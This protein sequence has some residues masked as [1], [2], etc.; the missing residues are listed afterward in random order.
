MKSKIKAINNVAISFTLALS[1]FAFSSQIQADQEDVELINESFNEI[2]NGEIPDNWIL[3][4][5]NGKV[6][7]G[8]LVLSSSSASRPSRIVVPIDSEYGNYTFEADMTFE[9]SVADSRWASLMY[10]IQDENN[11]YQFAARKGASA[12]NGLEFAKRIENRWDVFQTNSYHENFHYN[13]SYHLKIVVSRDRVQQFVDN[14]LVI[15][16]AGATEWLDGDIGFQVSGSKVLFDNVKVTTHDEELPPIEESDAFL[17]DEAETNMINP[18]TII[19]GPEYSGDSSKS[20]S[21]L[22]L[23][24]RNQEG[25]LE[26]NDQPLNEQ[27]KRIKNKKIP[28]LHVEQEGLQEQIVQSLK[29]TQTTDIHVVS[30]NPDIVNSIKEINPKIRSG[31]VYDGNSLNTNDLRN[32]P[33]E[34]HSSK[35]KLVLIPQK[36]LTQEIV[37]YLHNRMVAVWGVGADS[38][39][40]THELI[41]TGVD[42]IVTNHPEYTVEAFSQFPENTIVQRPIVAAH[43]GVP[44]LA[45]ENTMSSYR[46]AYDLEADMIETDIHRTKDGHLVT[47]HDSTVDRTTDGTGAVTE[48]TLDEI[49]ELD[50][51]ITFSKEFSGEHVPTFKEFL[52]E[53]K[54]KDVVLLVELKGSGLEEQVNEEIQEE[55]MMDKVVI[56]NFNLESMKKFNQIQPK[57]ATGYLFSAAVPGSYQDKLN[58]AKELVDYGTISN[59]TLNASYGSLYSE[60]ITYMRQR[61]MLSLHW[62]FR[63]EAPF[64]DKLRAGL[65]GPITDYTQWL[66]HSPIN[67]ESPIKK[68]NLKVGKSRSIQ[69]KGF[70]SYRTEERV[71]IETELYVTN[72]NGVVRTE[73]NNIEAL[74]PGK[75]QV[76]IK[77][78]F[79]MLGQEWNLVSE[80][81]EVNVS[82]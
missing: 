41:H 72:N 69:A 24:K 5:G 76:F 27:L 37:H 4:E 58:N 53:F 44:S 74:S 1:L 80:P 43:R 65:I 49:Q 55:G 63:G 82:N 35:S 73:G 20:A 60:F 34:V 62:T 75:A 81:I 17:P 45:P 21:S 8:K 29:E 3:I 23:V 40:S 32:L 13:K 66:T 14:E 28:V 26:A 64:A 12:L 67:L 50:A 2:A 30:S 68:V 36:L 57:L 19:A 47:I 59:V 39:D 25:Q 52:Q 15:D 54:G 71:N 16:S 56:Q 6:Q 7:D 22:L 78:T 33:S 38:L 42:G 18:P 77:H 46:L 48:L 9:S 79:T 31:L 11:Y 10:R 70:L 61:G 51:G